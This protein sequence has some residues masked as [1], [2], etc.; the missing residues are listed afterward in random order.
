MTT[1]KGPTLAVL[2]AA[3]GEAAQGAHRAAQVLQPSGWPMPKGYAN[4]MAADGRLVV[5][6]VAHAGPAERAGVQPGD[7]VIDVAGERPTALADF[8][9]RVWRLGARLVWLA[10]FLEVPMVA[11]RRCRSANAEIRRSGS[12]SVTP[13]LRLKAINGI[14]RAG[15]CARFVSQFAIISR[16]MGTPSAR[17]SSA[18]SYC[19]LCAFRRN[20]RSLSPS[21]IN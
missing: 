12:R 15:I 13:A 14:N 10:F 18:N 1:Q 5:G 3:K 17:H 21:L 2:P 4:G 19:D 11:R 6:G 20:E 8:F 9:R 16:V 7:L